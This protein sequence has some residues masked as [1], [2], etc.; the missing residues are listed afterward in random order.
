MKTSGEFWIQIPVAPKYEIS[1]HGRVRNIRTGKIRKPLKS[2]NHINQM[3]LCVD[4]EKKFFSIANLLWL[5][6]GLIKKRT[7]TSLPVIIS[8]GNER[9]FFDSARAA[10]RF[11]GKREH[12]AAGSAYCYLQK[13]RKEIFGWRI[14]YQR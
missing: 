6:H 4:S 11:L 13:R 14:N 10:S 3:S 5:V 8:K 9:Y 7:T 12:Y 1:N 2:K